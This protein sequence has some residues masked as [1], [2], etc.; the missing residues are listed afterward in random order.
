VA[1]WNVRGLTNK[2]A[3]IQKHISNN[4]IDIFFVID[5]QTHH[6]LDFSFGT[7]TWI[8][9]PASIHEVGGKSHRGMGAWSRIPIHTVKEDAHNVWVLL[10]PDELKLIPQAACW[11]CAGSPIQAM[12]RSDCEAAVRSFQNQGMDIISGGD[13]GARVRSAGDPVLNKEGTLLRC[14]MEKLGLEHWDLDWGVPKGGPSRAQIL[15]LRDQSVVCQR[16]TPDHG[17][18]SANL[19]GRMLHSTFSRSLP[20]SDHFAL[21][22]QWDF[23]LRRPIHVP[24]TKWIRTPAHDLQFRQLANSNKSWDLGDVEQFS[25][26][27]LNIAERSHLQVKSSLPR[28]HH[29]PKAARLIINNIKTLQKQAETL[30]S[31]RIHCRIST[32]AHRLRMVLKNF[33]S[34]DG[35]NPSRPVNESSPQ[36]RN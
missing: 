8:S 6:A 32:M 20:G 34:T 24:S 2:V 17:F 9:F 15:H 3:I 16:S 11:P 33:R 22:S 12:A 18:A 5:T 25:G 10:A 31:R 23:S 7:F 26:A 4:D 21:V 14:S 35:A 19:R 27:L 29:P 36:R 30:P 28:P 13:F 1:W